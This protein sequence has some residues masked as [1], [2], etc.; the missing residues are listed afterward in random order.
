LEIKELKERLEIVLLNELG[1]YTFVNGDSTPAIGIDYNATYPPP[2]TV[3]RGLECVIQPQVMLNISGLLGGKQIESQSYV[4]LK[5]WDL[6]ES[7][8]CA[9]YKIIKDSKLSSNI[10]NGGNR[11]LPDGELQNLEQ[12]R[13]IFRTQEVLPYQA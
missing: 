8:L 12:I 3:V 9:F 11:V 1:T 7:T 4:Y 2:G 13:L 6:Q 10:L 5:Q